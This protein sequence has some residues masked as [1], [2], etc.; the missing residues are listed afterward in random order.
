MD[1]DK[2]KGDDGHREKVDSSTQTV[3]EYKYQIPFASRWYLSSF[4]TQFIAIIC[5]RIRNIGLCIK[6]I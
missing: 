2:A 5:Q 3:R 1:G 4:Q 6:L